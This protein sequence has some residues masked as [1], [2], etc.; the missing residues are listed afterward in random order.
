[1]TRLVLLRAK[2]N[3]V[4][5]DSENKDEDTFLF[6]CDNIRERLDSFPS[7]TTVLLSMAKDN[8]QH[9]VNASSEERPPAPDSK[10]TASIF[11]PSKKQ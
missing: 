11:L 10:S 2:Y 7:W 6:L 1:M 4:T 3:G 5:I 8:K 9:S